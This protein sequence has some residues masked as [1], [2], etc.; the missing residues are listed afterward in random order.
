MIGQNGENI[1]K[2]RDAYP[3]VNINFPENKGASNSVVGKSDFVN[4]R[5]PKDQVEKCMQQL[6]KNAKELVSVLV[7][8]EHY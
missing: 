2:L 3:D 5:G 4:V 8:S 7:H 6:K 1:R